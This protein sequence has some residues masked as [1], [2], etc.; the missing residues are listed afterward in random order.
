MSTIVTLNAIKKIPNW[1]LILL[2][3]TVG[4]CCGFIAH[5]VLM[6]AAAVISEIFI[7]LLK[8]VSGPIIFLSLLSTLTG[9]KDMLAARSLGLGILRY[10]L[11]T[12]VIASSVALI[13]FVVI[14]PA[15]PANAV[16]PLISG[17][18]EKVNQ[19]GYLDYLMMIIPDN[20]FEPFIQGQVISILLMA[21][22]LSI[23][24]LSLPTH[25]KTQLAN[26]FSAMLQQLCRS[27]ALFYTYYHWLFGPW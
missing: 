6:N 18:A 15:S 12:T 14:A 22:V 23:A 19:S 3:A 8:L 20:I 9:M 24:V 1:L 17:E 4:V 2:A 26:L 7:R 10:T 11:L 25:H 27:H 13:L 5:P 16:I 21:L